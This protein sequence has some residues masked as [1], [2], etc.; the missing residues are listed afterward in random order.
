M[1][2][3]QGLN[4]RLAKDVNNIVARFYEDVT[5]DDE[6]C[7]SLS[8]V[9]CVRIALS[10]FLSQGLTINVVTP[11]DATEASNL[12]VVVVSN[13]PKLSALM[14]F[15]HEGGGLVDFRWWLRNRWNCRVCVVTLCWL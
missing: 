11:G 6:D 3:P 12:P 15:A 1:T 9:A 10:T 14:A 5:A 4:S 2:L 7:K 8:L 13:T